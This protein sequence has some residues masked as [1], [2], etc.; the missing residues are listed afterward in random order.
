MAIQWT[1]WRRTIDANP[2][3]VKRPVDGGR[4]AVVA[5]RAAPRQSSQNGVG[6]FAGAGFRTIVRLG[7]MGRFV[8]QN[9]SRQGGTRII[10]HLQ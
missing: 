6:R 8:P 9:L 10:G 5:G 3:D 7:P 2:T 4:N 1:G